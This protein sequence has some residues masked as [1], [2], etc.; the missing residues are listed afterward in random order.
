MNHLLTAPARIIVSFI[1]LFELR[2]NGKKPKLCFLCLF[3]RA[4]KR[5]RSFPLHSR[6]FFFFFLEEITKDKWMK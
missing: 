1:K 4:Q 3:L 6:G 5:D 2:R